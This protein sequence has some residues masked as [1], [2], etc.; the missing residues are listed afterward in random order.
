MYQQAIV[1]QPSPSLIDGITS[2]NLGKPDYN[3]ALLQ[4]RQYIEA[5]QSCGVEVTVLP[6]DDSFP[7][8]CFIED[9]ALLTESLAILTRPG[10]SSR[11]GEVALNK[12]AVQSF[13]GDKIKEIHAPGTVEGGDVLRVDNHF[14]IG[15]SART[16]H[17][18][19]KQ[20]IKILDQVGYSA[21]VVTL[22]HVLHLK[23]G[24]SYLDNGDLLVSGEFLHHPAFQHLKR[25]VIDEQENYAANCIFVNGT[26]LLP[27]GFPKTRRLIEHLGYP[28]LEMDTSEFRKVDGGLSCLSLRF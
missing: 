9:P 1:R 17:E 25:H 14:Y 24:V 23:T 8:S 22:K 26:V 11:L 4:H 20:L 18:G 2:V 3:K 10:V 6:P 13:Y 16:N 15:L 28:V 7:D 19:A 21:S 27:Q 5:L 12:A